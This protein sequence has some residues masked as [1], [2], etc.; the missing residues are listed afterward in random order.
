M[1]ACAGGWEAIGSSRS[2]PHS[3]TALRGSEGAWLMGAISFASVPETARGRPDKLSRRGRGAGVEGGVEV[4]IE[5]RVGRWSCVMLSLAVETG[6]TRGARASKRQNPARSFSGKRPRCSRPL[7]TLGNPRGFESLSAHCEESHVVVPARNERHNHAA[8]GGVTSESN[9]ALRTNAVGCRD[10][11]C[12]ALGRRVRRFLRR[13][14][15]ESIVYWSC[16][17]LVT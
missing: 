16:S 2:C 3:V 4:A 10:A 6:R 5:G 14:G 8:F 9:E 12:A 7:E 13:F 17:S 1:A 15:S 11:F